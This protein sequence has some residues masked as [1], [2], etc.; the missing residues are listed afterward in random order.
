MSPTLCIGLTLY[1]QAAI[2]IAVDARWAPFYK[3]VGTCISRLR[4]QR[5]WTQE[6]LARHL[7]LS[8]ASLANIE[9]GRQNVLLH[10]LYHI[11]GTLQVDMADLLPS[12]QS[13]HFNDDLPLPEDLSLSQRAQIASLIRGDLIPAKDESQ[14]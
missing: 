13:N 2:H 4:K 12:K 10:H 5:K 14:R 11:A 9:V 7:D 1:L 3:H 8:R 6:T